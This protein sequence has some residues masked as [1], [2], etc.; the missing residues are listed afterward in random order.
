MAR[1]GESFKGYNAIFLYNIMKDS[2]SYHILA[3]QDLEGDRIHSLEEWNAYP[4]KAEI[5]RDVEDFKKFLVR[6]SLSFRHAEEHRSECFL[7]IQFNLVPLN[8]PILYDVRRRVGDIDKFISAF[9]SAIDGKKSKYKV[10][11]TNNLDLEV[12]KSILYDLKNTK[13]SPSVFCHCFLNYKS[14]VLKDNKLIGITNWQYA[15]YYPPEFE[16]IIEKYMEHFI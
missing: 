15:G 10:K 1:I 6:E 14:L 12:A 2:A 8:T 13:F 7:G 5:E 9:S 11:L 16:A 4:Y 3:G